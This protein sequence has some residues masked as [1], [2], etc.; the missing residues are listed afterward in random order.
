[1]EREEYDKISEALCRWLD[2]Q[3]V[4]P[5]D[6]IKAL[7]HTVGI[8]IGAKSGGLVSLIEGLHLCYQFIHVAALQVL[9]AE[10]KLRI[11]Q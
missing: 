6:G 8:M 1:M 5:A 11:G 3:G 4:S 9:D 2:Q 10:K 7:S